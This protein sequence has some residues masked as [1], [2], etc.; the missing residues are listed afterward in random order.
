M[1]MT[2]DQEADAVYIYL[3]DMP[4]AWGHDLD[5]ERRINFGSD[6]KPRGIEMLGVS[7]GVNLKDLPEQEAVASALRAHGIQILAPASSS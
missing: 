2:Y 1:K 6:N 4:Y 3:R 7:H 5:S